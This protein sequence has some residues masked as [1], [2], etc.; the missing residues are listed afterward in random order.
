MRA[1]KEW[2]Q[3]TTVR[4]LR[5]FLGLTSYY[6]RF[7]VDYGRIAQPLHRMTGT[8]AFIWTSDSVEAFEQLK[9]AM[10]RLR[11]LALPD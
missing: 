1:I 2:P 9:G 4:E 5:S 6:R 11:L 3:P 10:V 7:L 8:D